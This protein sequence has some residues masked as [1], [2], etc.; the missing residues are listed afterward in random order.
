MDSEDEA[1]AQVFQSM[2]LAYR[3]FI[4]EQ[5]INM[6]TW[7]RDISKDPVGRK[8]KDTAKR[9]RDNWD[10]E[11]MESAWAAVEKRRFLLDG[12]LKRYGPP[13]T[14]EED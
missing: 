5:Y 3:K 14:Y 1:R 13:T 11:Y 10:Y 7:N 2:L 6:K 9:L 12:V 4:T 8:I